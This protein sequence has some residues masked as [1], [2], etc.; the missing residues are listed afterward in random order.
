MQPGTGRILTTDSG[1]L[2]R[3]AGLLLL[4]L[5]R[6]AGQPVDEPRF[7]AEVR[8]A[9]RET[10]HRQADAG[11]DLLNDGETGKPS[12]ATYVKNR[13]TGFGGDGSIEQVAASVMALQ[14]FPDFAERMA[15]TMASATPIRFTSCDGPVR[16]VG[17]RAVQSDI[18]SR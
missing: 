2:P 6:E 4:V 17:Q 13:L 5:A 14:D 8:A 7:R 1:S 16:Y 15:Q 12:Y 11:V 9:V 18:R 3:P 10:V